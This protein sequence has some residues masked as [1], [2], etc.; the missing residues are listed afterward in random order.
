M[1]DNSETSDDTDTQFAGR[2]IDPQTD[3]PARSHP[4]T[5]RGAESFYRVTVGGHGDYDRTTHI[6]VEKLGEG[7]YRAYMNEARVSETALFAAVKRF[8]DGP[9]S[10]VDDVELY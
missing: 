6:P 10:L 1:N 5:S 3:Y 2:L 7:S 4:A 9:D 8:L